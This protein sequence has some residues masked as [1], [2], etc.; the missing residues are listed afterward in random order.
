MVKRRPI[1][2]FDEL[3]NHTVEFKDCE[4]VSSDDES[5]EIKTVVN[6][7]NTNPYGYAHGGYLFTLCDTLC[8]LMGYFLGYYVVTQQANINYLKPAKLN[9]VLTIR[10]QVLHSGKYSDVMDVKITD[11]DN[12]L[13]A[14]AQFTLFNTQKID[15]K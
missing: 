12:E 8:G 14:K 9:D 15:I 6:E 11:Q 3:F 10:A 5:A 13:I 1:M 7:S 2:S 4:L